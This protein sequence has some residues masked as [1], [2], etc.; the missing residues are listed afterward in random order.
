MSNLFN[1]PVLDK[2]YRHIIKKVKDAETV[3]DTFI[4]IQ[5]LFRF[6]LEIKL[7]Y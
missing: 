2:I 4:I 7:F 3:G 5:K 1:N 6:D